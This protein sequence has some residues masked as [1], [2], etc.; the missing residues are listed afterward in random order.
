MQNSN[1]K[2]IF[3]GTSDFAVPAL[4]ALHADGFNIIAVVSVPDQ[5]AGRKKTL[6]PPPLKGAAQELNIPVYQPAS[7][8]DDAFFKTFDPLEP[9]ICIVAA[10]GKIIPERYLGVPRYGF[11]NI[12]PSLLPAY[13]G[14]TPVQTAILNGDTET[15]VTIMGVDKE[16]D[17]GQIFMQESVRIHPDET[18]RELH[19]RLA[20]IGAALLARTIA[21]IDTFK[22]REQE[23]DLATF[24]KLYGREEGRLD[25]S[26]PGKKIYDRIRALNPEPGT[27]TMW[28]GKILNIKSAGLELSSSERPG[29]VSRVDNNIVV[30]TGTCHLI[31]RTIQLEGKHET[32]AASFVNGHKEFLGT[33][34]Q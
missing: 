5:P 28:N 27:W 14:P 24:T 32:D 13:R 30:G 6:T 33:I 20:D 12:H 11:L 16:M 7:L 17:H 9:D 34:L 15:G 29:S 19:N 10:Y 18:Y 4:H 3:W 23:H 26:E 8:K 25:W 22:P 1:L 31:L 2:V 21:Q